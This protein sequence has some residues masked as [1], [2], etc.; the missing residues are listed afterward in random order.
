MRRVAQRVDLPLENREEYVRLHAAVWPA[1]EQALTAAGI[2]NYSIFLDGT[3]LFAYF[4]VEDLT[5]LEQASARVAADP[6]TQR[7]WTLTDPLQRRREGTAEGEQ[8]FTLT[9]VWHL[10]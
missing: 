6:E 2:R 9:E 5:T 1:V 10:D 3:D 8:W 7:W 4:E